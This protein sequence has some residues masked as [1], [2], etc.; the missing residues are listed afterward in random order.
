MVLVSEPVRGRS[1]YGYIYIYLLG[2]NICP[3][4]GER[5]LLLLKRGSFFKYWRGEIS[6]QNNHA[7]APPP[8]IYFNWYVLRGCPCT[9][10]TH[11]PL[12]LLA[13]FAAMATLK[14]IISHNTA[15]FGDIITN[16]GNYRQ[17][18]YI[19]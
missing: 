11:A 2:T 17:C 19:L 6:P 1:E 4:K 15:L 3:P 5:F 16:T 14:T 12:G 10:N 18:T 13:Y 7:I 9:Y 8:P